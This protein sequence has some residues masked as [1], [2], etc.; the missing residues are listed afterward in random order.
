MYL[1]NPRQSSQIHWNN[2]LVSAKW[3]EPQCCQIFSTMFFSIWNFTFTTT[4]LQNTDSQGKAPLVKPFRNQAGT[5]R[6]CSTWKKSF[7]PNASDIGNYANNWNTALK[8]RLQIDSEKTTTTSDKVFFF[9]ERLWDCTELLKLEEQASPD[10]MHHACCASQEEHQ[11]GWSSVSHC[12]FRQI[13]PYYL[14]LLLLHLIHQP[15]STFGP[16][17]GC[18]WHLFSVMDAADAVRARWSPH[19]MKWAWHRFKSPKPE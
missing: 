7:A 17:L 18:L 19:V 16:H 13:H 2:D 15:Q 11:K 12:S 14:V 3:E 6:F 5:A 1:C 10:I 9:S 8:Q 4:V